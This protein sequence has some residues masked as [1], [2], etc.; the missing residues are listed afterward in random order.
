MIRCLDFYQISEINER[1][2][3]RHGPYIRKLKLTCA[4]FTVMTP[5]PGTELHATRRSDLLSAKPEL[6]DML[7][8][9][10]LT[11]FWLNYLEVGGE[12][13]SDETLKRGTD[14][15]DLLLRNHLTD[16]ARQEFAL[17]D[18]K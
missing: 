7:H 15:L 10:L 2:Y 4:T 17:R 11:L 16:A 1:K 13:G 6:N 14:H 12:E 9:L 8:A 3:S 18:G 5:L